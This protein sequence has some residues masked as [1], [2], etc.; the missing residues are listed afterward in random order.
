MAKKK[1]KGKDGKSAKAAKAPTRVSDLLRLPAG[2]VDLSTY[3]SRATPGFSGDKAAAEAECAKSE[4][5]LAEAAGGALRRGGARGAG[6]PAGHG[7]RAARTASIRH[8]FGQ[9]RPAGRAASRRSRSRPRRSARTTSCGGS[10]ALPPG[11]GDGHLQPLALRGRAGRA[12]AQAGAA[13][14][15]GEALRPDQRIREPSSPT[16]GTHRQVLPAHLQGRAEER[17][18]ARL[19]DPTSTGSSTRATS[20]SA[21]AGTT[22]RTAYEVALERC[23][24]ERRPGTSCPA[25]RKWF[26]NWAV[27]RLLPR[28]WRNRPG[29]SGRRVRRHGGA[30]AGPRQLNPFDRAGQAGLTSRA[31]EMP[32][33]AVLDGLGW[34]DGWAESFAPYTKRGLVPVRVAAVDRSAVDGGGRGRRPRQARRRRPR[35]GRRRSHGGPVQRRLGWRECVAGWAYDARV[36]LLGVPQ[37]Y[38]PPDGGVARAGPRRQRRRRGRQAIRTRRST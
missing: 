37:S 14:E 18:L 16:S 25:D 10:S 4:P 19:D 30:S 29:L 17:L 7:H 9:R 22:T 36:L 23:S 11:A 38:A 5:Y 13:G 6:R 33:A 32:Q 1:S 3:D 20:R 27:G 34:D 24:T 28:R 35:S 26:R 15:C 12:G 2:P 8:V 31:W 21:S